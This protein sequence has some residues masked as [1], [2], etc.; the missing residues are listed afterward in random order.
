MRHPGG[1]GR[2]NKKLNDEI[3]RLKKMGLGIREIA[4]V[5]NLHP[6]TVRRKIELRSKGVSAVVD[7]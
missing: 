6:E 3:M 7:K 2:E 4:R 1:R 5:K